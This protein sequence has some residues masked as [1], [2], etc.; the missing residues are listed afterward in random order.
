RFDPD[1]PLLPYIAPD[2]TAN[3]A[4]QRNYLSQMAEALGLQE[5]WREKAAQSRAALFEH[6]FD[7]DDAFFYDRDR[8][9]RF[10]RVQSDV[11]LRVLACE[12]GD[13]ELFREALDRYLLNTRKFFAKFP[14]TSIA[15]DDPRF[16]PTF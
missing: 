10:V 3:V 1:N 2:L 5:D 11:L 6:C 14:L 16:D 13:G 12:I 4:C 8:H 7:P 9:N 15:L